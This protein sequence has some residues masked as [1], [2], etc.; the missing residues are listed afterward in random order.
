MI[1]T[2]VITIDIPINGG[3]YHITI[4]KQDQLATLRFTTSRPQVKITLLIL[5][6]GVEVHRSEGKGQVVIPALIFRRNP[7]E[8]LKKTKSCK[9]VNNHLST[10]TFLSV[11]CMMQ[12]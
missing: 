4:H 12:K 11:S 6:N 5:D 9:I 10:T 7:G 2:N 8:E 3:R 1:I